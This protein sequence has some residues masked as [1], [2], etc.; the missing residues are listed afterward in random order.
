M[1]PLP[2]IKT[3]FFCILTIAPLL[4]VENVAP[5]VQFTDLVSTL[6][7]NYILI[8]SDHSVFTS[9][10][11]VNASWQSTGWPWWSVVPLFCRSYCESRPNYIWF[12][13]FR[14]GADLQI[15]ANGNKLIQN[16]KSPIFSQVMFFPYLLPN[17]KC[18]SKRDSVGKGIRRNSHA[19]L[20]HMAPQTRHRRNHHQSAIILITP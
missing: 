11:F 13:W 20:N 5:T 8:H 12:Q 7:A 10:T 14:H 18:E 2:W 6:T 17:R 3:K 15:N 1:F 16:W 9:T 4:T 19:V